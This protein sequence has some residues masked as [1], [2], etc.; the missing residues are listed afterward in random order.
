[1]TVQFRRRSVT[2]GG[3]ALTLAVALAVVSAFHGTRK[4]GTDSEPLKYSAKASTPKV[5]TANTPSFK[6]GEDV[7][8]MAKIAFVR[9]DAVY[10][11]DAR[12]KDSKRIGA[13]YAPDIS[14]TGDS[15]AFTVNKD[16]SAGK[17]TIKLFRFESNSAAEFQS[18][19]K[20]NVR[21]PHWSHDGTKL[22]FQIIDRTG[23]VGIL[24][25][26]TGV[27]H[28]V[29]QGLVFSDHDGVPSALFFSSWSPDDQSIICQDL[30]SIFEIAL[31]G[32]VLNR[33]PIDSVIPVNEISSATRF[34]FSKDKKLLLFNGMWDPDKTAIY[35][36]NFSDHKLKRLTPKSM[37]GSEPLWLPSQSEILFSRGDDEQGDGS[38]L[39]VMSL[40]SDK[41]TVILK[42]ASSGS[43]ST[44]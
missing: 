20:L 8:G 30:Y 3:G 37:D 40:G 33:I 39:C 43:Y 36:F 21:N 13:G 4:S 19:A 2:L 23:R 10:L 28:D 44:R 41:V 18:L 22:A 29:T 15:V 17:T 6:P 38:D 11:Y 42:D 5:L 32:D 35:L 31:N 12:T 14:P 16:E 9:N 25:V 27:W 26:S 1:M 7:H 24:D 34:Q